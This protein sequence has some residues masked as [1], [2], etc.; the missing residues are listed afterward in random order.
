M[1]ASAVA[2][3]RAARVRAY[4]ARPDGVHVVPLEE[5]LDHIRQPAPDAPP[6]WLAIADPGPSEGELLRGLGF[7]PLAV[8]DTLRGRQRPKLE[9]YDAYAFVV[10]YAAH[11]NPQRQRMALQELHAFLGPH[12]LV[13]VHDGTI[14]AVRDALARWRAD[15][16]RFPDALALGYNLLDAVVDSYFPVVDYLSDRIDA[17]EQEVFLGASRGTVAKLLQTRRELAF[18][19]RVLGPMREIVG[20]I[21]R[22]DLPGRR[23]EL[24]PYFQDVYDHLLRLAEEIDALREL[25]TAALDAHLSAASHQLND[26]VRT[27]TAWSIILMSASWIAGVYGMNFAHMPELH[28]RWGYPFALGLMLALALALAVYF[29]RRGWL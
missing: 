18:L 3:P 26:I 13:T 29:R 16:R 6:V 9:R 20:A 24:L 15:P 28:W 4:R 17:L 22:R 10:V 8:E 7:H 25:L 21:L 23:P 1:S 12:Y 27:L 11:I 5:A 2:A 19:R 14:P